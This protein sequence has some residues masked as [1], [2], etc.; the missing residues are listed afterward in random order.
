M[1]EIRLWG[2][3]LA[4]PLSVETTNK[5]LHYQEQSHTSKRRHRHQEKE[6]ECLADTNHWGALCK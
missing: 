3:I 6:G 5:L 2:A 1:P 4:R